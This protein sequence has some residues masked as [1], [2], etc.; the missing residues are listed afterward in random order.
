VHNNA[1]IQGL[2]TP[3]SVSD[4]QNAYRVNFKQQ[5]K[6]SDIKLAVLS[7]TNKQDSN[8]FRKPIHT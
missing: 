8:H 4:V 1:V 6:V 5:S 7:L 3:Y 2:E